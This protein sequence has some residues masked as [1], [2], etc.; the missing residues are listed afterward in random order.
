MPTAVLMM[1]GR[2]AVMKVAKVTKEFPSLKAASESGGPRASGGTVRRNL[3]DQIETPHGPI[4]LPDQRTRSN[5][6]DRRKTI[7]RGHTPEAGKDV[8]E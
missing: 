5:A 3:E 7:A 6:G 4:A 1:I 2:M 8:P